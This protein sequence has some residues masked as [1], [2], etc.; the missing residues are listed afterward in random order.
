MPEGS[1]SCGIHEKIA[2]IT[3]FHPRSNSLPGSLL[4]AIAAHIEECGKNDSVRVI[5]LQSEGERAFCG[6]ASFDELQ[7]IK[8]I[9]DGHRFF[10][11]FAHIILAVR[12]CPKFVVARVQGKA[13]GGGVG[14][15]SACDYTLAHQSAS[16]R[17]SE[18]A[19]GF[20]P[21]VISAAVERKV[22]LPAFQALAIDA[23]WR[24]A[25][26]CHAHGLYANVL[27]SLQDLDSSLNACVEKLAR[28]NPEAM[29]K[30]K[31]IFWEGTGHWPELLNTRAVISSKL[32]LTDFV[33][34]A[35]KAVN[36]SR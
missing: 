7:A 23:D 31:S 9:D 19:L 2:R 24:D 25:G 34:H 18:L 5:V 13:V 11:G 33:Q 22:G 26:W 6:G 14:V 30:M 36:Q 3:F 28:S 10:M 20:G 15:I 29:A 17:L 21:F 27:P 35:V 1:V 4:E 16:V 32:A 12:S 8:N